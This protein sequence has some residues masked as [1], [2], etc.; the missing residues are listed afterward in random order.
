MWGNDQGLRKELPKRIRGIQSHIGQETGLILNIK[1]EKSQILWGTD[2]NIKK[3]LAQKEGKI[4]A[5]ENAGRV[6]P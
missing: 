4:N 6:P 2:Y 3:D 1:N 5:R